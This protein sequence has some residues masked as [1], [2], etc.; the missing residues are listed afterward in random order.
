MKMLSRAVLLAA[1]LVF[2]IGCSSRLQSFTFQTV[3]GAG[4][5]IWQS[6]RVA[7]D[8]ETTFEPGGRGG[9][10][11]PEYR[12]ASP[13]FIASAGQSFAF[14]YTSD[15]PGC[16]LTIF[17]DRH[18]VLK[19]LAL[20]VT[21][22]NPLR[23]LVPLERGDRIWGYQLSAPTPG[24]TLTM[25]AAGTAPFVHGFA[26]DPGLL[27]VDGSVEVL[28]ASA[29][30]VSARLTPAA[31]EEMGRGIWLVRLTLGEGSAGG[32]VTFSDQQGRIATFEVNP[33]AT[34]GTL[35]FARGSMPFVPREVRFAGSLKS[36]QILR[37]GAD[38][39]IPAD[40]GV[41]LTWDQSTWRKPDYEL[42]AWS[43]FP[44][45]LI[46]DMASY[47][48]QDAF[49]KRIAFFVEKAGHAGTLETR[50]ALAG[51]H[52]YNAHDYRAED[53][54]R[55]FTTAEKD[56][57][58]LSV[59]EQ[60]LAGLLA[61]N[62]VILKTADGYGPGEGCVLS[63]SR[64]SSPILRAL[65]LTHEC[66]HGVYFSLPAFRDATEAEWASL[67]PV[68]QAVW[69]S[70]LATHGY[71]TADHSLVVNEFQSYLMQQDRIGIWG[72]QNATLAKMRAASAR[73]AGLARQ[74]AVGHP[75]SFLKAFD[76]LDEALQAAG[77]PAGG[78]ALAVRRA[79]Q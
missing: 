53:L 22:G 74:L 46:L 50:A 48:L 7:R 79:E 40:P 67:S 45:V 13:L 5:E 69:Q 36:L 66:F 2:A 76:A 33:A 16:T 26:L 28:S 29:G 35:D 71:N 47:A 57:H 24:G 3:E 51:L 43:R 56:A 6:T 49:F 10:S 42:F 17:S 44:Q 58:G 11:S 60:V 54:A 77:G 23:Y 73:E 15:L 78:H 52:G 37:V 38:M 32:R 75:T 39:P 31:E 55:F 34:P 62:G 61:D 25:R 70:Y 20:P 30:A 9:L 64:S 19:T 68:E 41:I 63:I 59:E 21:S 18:K 4:I 8:R 12:L 14:S 65:L 27:T 72:F 1:G